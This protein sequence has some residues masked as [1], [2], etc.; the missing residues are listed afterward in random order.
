VPLTGIRCCAPKYAK[1]DIPHVVTKEQCLDCAA[2][3]TNTCEFTY[4]ILNLMYGE[5]QDRE[6]RISTTTL[7]SK[8]LRSEF[9]KR[10]EGYTESPRRL[11]PS[12]RGTQ[13]H[14]QLEKAARPG[15]VAE[16]RFHIDDFMGMGPLSGSPDL[17][18]VEEGIL[19]DYKTNKENP[20]FAYPWGDHSQQVNVNR[21][22]VD[23]ADWVEWQGKTYDPEQFRPKD[24][25][26]LVLVYID[27]NGPKPLE[28]TRSEDVS[29]KDGK[30]RKKVRVPD[31][32]GDEH[33]QQWIAERYAAVKEAFVGGR[34]PE[35]PPEFQGWE[36]PLCGF[37]PK[38][39]E[40]IEDFYRENPVRT[41][42]TYQIRR[43]A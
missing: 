2:S 16:A 25:Q 6:D 43:P 8:C 9:L 32:W 28:V 3:R 38:K 12:F 27:T 14:Q 20:R 23:H 10:A 15:S 18:D 26:A 13:F 21:Y 37:C 40:C 42:K 30:G 22:L 41:E 19:Y 7:T 17:L 34:L 24:W 1:S 39:H 5:V 33:A 31:I 4:E 29:T 35:I 36:H 11:W